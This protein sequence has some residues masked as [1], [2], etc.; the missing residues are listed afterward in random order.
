MNK[1]IIIGSPPQ[2]PK[3]CEGEVCLISYIEE[4]ED[5]GEISSGFH[6]IVRQKLYRVIEN[7]KE[8]ILVRKEFHEGISKERIRQIFEIHNLLKEAGIP[9]LDL[10]TD[11][12]H[13]YS[14]YLNQNGVIALSANTGNKPPSTYSSK[15]GVETF[16]SEKQKFIF[17][18]FDELLDKI[19]DIFIKSREVGV[20]LTLDCLFFLVDSLDKEKQN[21]SLLI[22]DFD[23]L[24][25]MKRRDITTL[26]LEELRCGLVEFIE[27]YTDKK[28][29]P[30]YLQQIEDKL[31][32]TIKDDEVFTDH[33][34]KKASDFDPEHDRIVAVG[35][36]TEATSDE[37]FTQIMNKKNGTNYEV[38]EIARRPEDI[39]E[40][41]RY[42]EGDLDDSHLD[43]FK[44]KIKHPFVLNGNLGLWELKTAQGVTLPTSV[45]GDTYLP[46]IETPDGLI[47]P[48][49]MGGDLDLRN[50]KEVGGLVFPVILEGCLNLK[51]LETAEGVILPTYIDWYLDLRSLKTAKGVTFPALL[52]G[53]LFLNNL[54][55]I[56]GL[57]LPERIG[58]EIYL[59]SLSM[60]DKEKLAEKYPQ[61][62]E[63]ILANYIYF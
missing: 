28:V 49:S 54:E 32:P 62:A 51:S 34:V 38:G 12:E 21:V 23:L 42:Y 63:K 15:D 40:N 3:N 20:W 4:L 41:T 55:T 14:P 58:G 30:E 18:N 16:D 33:G 31:N 10:Y 8:V 26:A 7:G 46:S 5:Q 1:K 24:E 48:I 9:V 61:H 45:E 39:N 27:K 6:G 25:K 44:N 43:I 60:E 50:L 47:L 11:G 29:N 19:I 22:G 52:V 36:I 59:D 57:E 56:E 13:I 37:K 53:D 17:N 2:R 35:P